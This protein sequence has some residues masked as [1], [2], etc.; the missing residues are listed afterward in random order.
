LL[1]APLLG[2]NYHKYSGLYLR[3]SLVGLRVVWLA[4]LEY[5][6]NTVCY[7]YIDICDPW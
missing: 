3:V 5:E 4:A 1:P 2:K 6:F 7:F